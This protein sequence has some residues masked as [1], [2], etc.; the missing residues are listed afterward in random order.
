MKDSPEFRGQMFWIYSGAE[1]VI[2]VFSIFASFAGFVQV[3]KAILYKRK[4]SN[5]LFHQIQKLSHSFNTPYELDTLLS[6]ITV[7]GS[8]IY[9]IFGCLAAMVSLPETKSL[10]VFSQ[11]ALLLIQVSLQGKE[12]QFPIF[13][14]MR[15]LD[16]VQLKI[17]NNV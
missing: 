11:C 15:A 7:T 14:C 9:A 3:D 16:Q 6:S 13:L 8:Y 2:L 17:L 12:N 10:V 1:I 5:P 4:E